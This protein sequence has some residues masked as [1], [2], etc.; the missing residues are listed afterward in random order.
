MEIQLKRSFE[1]SL[2]VFISISCFVFLSCS[3]PSAEKD[4]PQPGEPHFKE[5]GADNNSK[6]DFSGAQP[7]SL[8]A[9]EEVQR[10][11]SAVESATDIEKIGEIQFNG[12]HWIAES[13]YFSERGESTITVKNLENQKEMSILDYVQKED[14]LVDG[15]GELVLISDTRFTSPI[16]ITLWIRGIGL[17]V[18]RIFDPGASSQPIF[19][20]ASGAEI[21]V[22][23]N[24]KDHIFFS[25][26]DPDAKIIAFSEEEPPTISFDWPLKKGSKSPKGCKSIPPIKNNIGS[27]K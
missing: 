22:Y 15:K 6:S 4:H 17:G 11:P 9:S 10:S 23:E 8:Q 7:S 16:L 1:S 12:G 3:S 5:A 14:R 21:I 27:E 25:F 20:C 18:L 26:Q 13:R 19:E 24:K 2:S